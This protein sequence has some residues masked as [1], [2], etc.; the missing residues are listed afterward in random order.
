MASPK[1]AR[2][3]VD[4]AVAYVAYA[5]LTK[6]VNLHGPCAVGKQ[7]DTVLHFDRYL[8]TLDLQKTTAVKT[9]KQLA[10]DFLQVPEA[11][12]ERSFL[13]LYCARQS[14]E[15]TTG[16]GKVTI[17]LALGPLSPTNGLPRFRNNPSNDLGSGDALLVAHDL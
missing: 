14:K 15:R 3:S 7:L 5:E 1:I 16:V 10:T 12:L 11:K 17:F 4:R 13:M 9:A 6:F 8:N 2:Q